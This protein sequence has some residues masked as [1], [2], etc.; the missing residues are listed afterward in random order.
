MT[1]DTYYSKRDNDD[2]KGNC[3]AVMHLLATTL[4]PEDDEQKMQLCTSIFTTCK[5]QFHSYLILTQDVE[6]KPYIQVIN[7]LHI[8]TPP[9]ASTI[10][11]LSLAAWPHG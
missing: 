6:S 4:N 2:Y 11:L 1:Y 3:K 10:A 8:S 5:R 7:H 9:M